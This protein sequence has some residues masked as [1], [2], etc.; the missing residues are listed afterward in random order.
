M[1]W[2]EMAGRPTVRISKDHSWSTWNTVWSGGKQV[3]SANL[4]EAWD[5]RIDPLRG[6]IIAACW[7]A[8]SAAEFVPS[9]CPKPQT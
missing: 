4:H 1:D 6:W 2:R 7:L 5:G 3:G 9:F 8:A